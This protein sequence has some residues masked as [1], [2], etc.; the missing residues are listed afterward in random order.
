[1]ATGHVLHHQALVSVRGE[2]C[3]PRVKLRRGSTAEFRELCAGA[4]KC[5]S[6]YSQAKRGGLLKYLRW[7]FRRECNLLKKKK[8][9][10]KKR[11]ACILIGG[12]GLEK[13][14]TSEI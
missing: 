1:M 2:R 7:A 14:H 9:K 4:K 13:H 12:L 5:I 3:E 10:N 8:Q 11:E 6:C